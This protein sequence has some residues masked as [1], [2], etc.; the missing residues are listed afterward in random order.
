MRWAGAAGAFGACGFP[1]DSAQNKKGIIPAP[2]PMTLA[3]RRFAADETRKGSRR[4]ADVWKSDATPAASSAGRCCPRDRPGTCARAARP[5]AR[6]SAP[7]GC[8]RRPRGRSLA[9]CRLAPPHGLCSPLRR[10]HK[11]ALEGQR[12]DWNGVMG[13][14]RPRS[15][16]VPGRSPVHV[17]RNK[18]RLT[19]TLRRFARDIHSRGR[20]APCHRGS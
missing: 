2:R 18:T 14:L 9:K 12:R 1:V 6:R 8:R 11:P 3:E 15:R 19:R 10:P 17:A 16:A 4:D 5:S 13:S 20:G 7:P